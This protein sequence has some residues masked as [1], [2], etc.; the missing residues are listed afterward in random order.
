MIP[1]KCRHHNPLSRQA[2]L[3]GY[4]VCD[5]YGVGFVHRD[6]RID[7]CNLQDRHYLHLYDH[8]PSAT[9]GLQELQDRN[10]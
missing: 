1:S 6:E 3:L 4:F 9:L 7:L 2:R 8:C 10:V 5:P